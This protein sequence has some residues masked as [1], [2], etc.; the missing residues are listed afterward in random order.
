MDFNS[1]MIGSEDAE[2]L[3]RYY[4]KLF[5]KPAMEM[6]GFAGWNVGSGWIT[7]GPHDGVKGRNPEPGRLI[8]NIE[9]ADVRRD[10]ELLCEAGA[11][12]VREP[13][14]PQ[15]GSG[16]LIATF[17]DPDDNYFQLMSSM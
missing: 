13:Y 12:V 15:E 3:A 4:T 10:F 11:T 8:V 6:D 1:V 7:V 9:T 14:E 16:M 5:G 17:C 2:G